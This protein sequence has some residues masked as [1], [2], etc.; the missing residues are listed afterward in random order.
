[1]RVKTLRCS[2]FTMCKTGQKKS[3]YQILIWNWPPRNFHTESRQMRL[4]LWIFLL[5]T[6]ISQEVTLFCS[7]AIML[8]RIISY[9]LL[10]LPPLQ[11][12]AKKAH[13]S[14]MWGSNPASIQG[15]GFLIRKRNKRRRED[16]V[17]IGLP[18]NGCCLLFQG[19]LVCSCKNSS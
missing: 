14:G 17:L 3:H 19:P 10:P 8:F 5:F 2:L 12:G 6:R 18:K 13:M 11:K 16:G 9:I 4:F 15:L 1:M 7:L